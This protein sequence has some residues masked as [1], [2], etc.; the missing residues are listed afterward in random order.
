MQVFRL[1][2]LQHLLYAA[3][4]YLLLIPAAAASDEPFT[5][6]ANWGGTG[7][8]ETPNARVLAV[9]KY[10]MGWQEISPYR[11]FY[12]TISPLEGL[13]L[14][15]RITEFKDTT[16][17][18]QST[19]KD[20]VLNLKYQ[21][22]R[23]GKYTPA[24]AVGIM[25]PHGTRIFAS[26]Y[27]VASKQIYPFDFSVGFGNGRYGEKPLEAQTE[28]I[29]LEILSSPRQWLSDSQ[30]FAGIQFA[31][32]DNIIFTAEYSP[33]LYHLQ[34]LDPARKK[35][36]PSAVPSKFNYSVHYR[37][38]KWSVISASYQRG[39][40]LGF[41]FST[42]FEIGNPMIP[43]FDNIYSEVPADRQYTME[44]RIA[45]ALGRS[46][47]VNIGVQ[48]S[49][50]AMNIT[51]QNTKYLFGPKALGVIL[52]L[53]AQISDETIMTFN[54]T[55]H[56]NGVSGI[57]L[58]AN[59][60]DILDL[61]TEKLS[62][63]EFLSLSEIS[64][65]ITA[66]STAPSTSLKP[67]D[68]GISPSV[69]TFLNDPSG[70]L[71][72]RAG[73]SAWVKYFPWE[74]TTLSASV[75]GF[76]LNNISTSNQPLSIPV[77]SDIV[78]YKKN[79]AVLGKLLVD[80]TRRLTPDIYAR[81][82]AGIL[83]AQYAGIDGE[84]A[85]PILGGRILL[86]LSGSV[87]KKRDP[88]SALKLKSN[89]IKSRYETWFMNAQLNIPEIDSAVAVKTGQFLAGDRGMQ[90]T[91]S[92]HI[93]GVK[94]WAWY[95]FTNT[96]I[97][98]DSVNRGYHDKGVG[99]SIPLRL[100]SGSDSRT[101]FTQTLSPWTRDVAQDI[102]HFNGLFDIIGRNTKIYLDKDR[103]KLY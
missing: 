29:K 71:K 7:L 19:S 20:K 103:K 49:G 83:E 30:L 60:E 65:K 24:V 36:F 56:E 88:D 2:H 73:A 1:R 32:S 80:Q 61:Q 87:V 42:E 16:F 81:A 9:K 11:H 52:R 62:I 93:N 59:R 27:L 90:I 22:F 51:A 55:L 34:T 79:K 41:S 95:S 40:Q 67:Y 48:R 86:G 13:E 8:I 53:L 84:L 6:P 43:I 12:V 17:A 64:T 31:P 78:S 92:K 18:S 89:D 69:Q 3:F 23:E 4:F 101:I 37:P 66:L 57:S 96:D 76:P 75:E 58:I 35:S 5:Y 63:D 38:T 44:D 39:E 74:S 14:D 70:F 21:I 98:S 26:Q 82:T 54:I 45:K 47:F 10:R 99:V 100:F 102:E 50:S 68:Y 91:L 77:R 94:L 25:D 28:N 15:G 72:Y 85:A 33:I 46:G 97:F